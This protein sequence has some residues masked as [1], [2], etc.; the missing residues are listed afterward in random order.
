MVSRNAGPREEPLV[1]R[2]VKAG[3]V[4]DAIV[5][6]MPGRAIHYGLSEPAEVEQAQIRT[7]FGDGGLL[8]HGTSQA[9]KTTASTPA[10][11]NLY[12][13]IGVRPLIN[14]KGT[15][16]IN[17]FAGPVAGNSMS[18]TVELGEYGHAQWSATKETS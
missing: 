15:Y 5:L 8:L 2:R 10:G 7:A 4:S 13:D 11:P 6:F 16:T 18:G 12:E 14:A 9:A 1:F 3:I 17:S